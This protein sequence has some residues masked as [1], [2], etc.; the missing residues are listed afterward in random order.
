[1]LQGGTPHRVSQTKTQLF[2]R[3]GSISKYTPSGPC[4]FTPSSSCCSTGSSRLASSSTSRLLRRASVRRGYQPKAGS[5]RLGG[6]Q[7]GSGRWFGG[8]VF[9][10]EG[11]GK[12]KE[13]ERT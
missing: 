3:T 8:K 12:R 4:S 13:R 2:Q 7:T 11:G 1:M 10:G 9:L 5:L 6:R